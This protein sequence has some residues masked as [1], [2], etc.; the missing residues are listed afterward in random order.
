MSTSSIN[1]R[2]CKNPLA[3]KHHS[4]RIQVCT[5][6]RVVLTATGAELTCRCGAV[7]RLAEKRAA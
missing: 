4:G 6:V 2:T 7:R 3:V 5:G 1:C